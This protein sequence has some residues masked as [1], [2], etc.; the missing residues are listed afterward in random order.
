MLLIK[1]TILNINEINAQKCFRMCLFV[2]ERLTG[3]SIVFYV[4][5]WIHSIQI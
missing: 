5:L 4:Y 2:C 1:I 3:A